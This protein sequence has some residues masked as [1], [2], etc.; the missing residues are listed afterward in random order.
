MKNIEHL[1]ILSYYNNTFILKFRSLYAHT[2]FWL[3]SIILF[4]F[5][6]ICNYAYAAGAGPAAHLNKT[7]Q[8]QLR[9][10][11]QN[12]LTEQKKI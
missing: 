6:K 9:H 12:I 11:I 4:Y 5:N 10:I 3:T 7:I 8:D 2:G 1:F